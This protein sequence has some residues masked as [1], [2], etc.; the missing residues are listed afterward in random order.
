MIY[1]GLSV[2]EEAELF[3]KLQDSRR[4]V[5][6]VEKFLAKIT[7]GD[8]K[9]MMIMEAMAEANVRL[10]SS[11]GQS[12]PRST[13]AIKAVEDVYD[14]VGYDGLLEVFGLI[15]V[16]WGD[17][18]Q[19]YYA[20]VIQGV[21]AFVR[22]FKGGY[23]RKVFANKLSGVTVVSIRQMANLFKTGKSNSEGKALGKALS[24]V[25]NKGRTSGT[26]ISWDR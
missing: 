15:N 19:A 26:R 1:E 7:Q 3:W 12:P 25:Y 21:G 11:N 14:W 5:S 4:N 6:S 13:R 20:D 2:E 10:V 9:A 22:K 17:D 24:E 18:Q 8:P 16:A 23:D